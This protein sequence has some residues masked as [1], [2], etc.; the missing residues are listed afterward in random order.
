MVDCDS[1]ES[2]DVDPDADDVAVAD[3]DAVITADDV[4]VAVADSVAVAD[5][6]DVAVGVHEMSSGEESPVVGHVQFEKHASA[7]TPSG[8]KEPIGQIEH[9][10]FDVAAMTGEKV[11]AGHAVQTS[12]PTPAK[13]PAGHASSDPV[14]HA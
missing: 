13:V 14:P 7:L 5:P 10:A 11:P 12:A 3:P 1:D 4:A 2:A 8:Q 9:V 6:D